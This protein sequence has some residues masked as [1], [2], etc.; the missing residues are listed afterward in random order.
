LPHLADTPRRSNSRPSDV[1]RRLVERG[2]DPVDGT[3]LQFA[4]HIRAKIQKWA[5]VVRD[6]NIQAE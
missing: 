5:K 6:A 4:D 1:K 3:P 2:V